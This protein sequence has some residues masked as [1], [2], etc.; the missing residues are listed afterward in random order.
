MTSLNSSSQGLLFQIMSVKILQVINQGDY[1]KQ[2]EFRVNTCYSYLFQISKTS[3][4]IPVLIFDCT[5]RAKNFVRKLQALVH[6]RK[7]NLLLF[8]HHLVAWSEYSSKVTRGRKYG[9]QQIP[10]GRL[11]NSVPCDRL[12]ELGWDSLGNSTFLRKA[13]F[14]F[15]QTGKLGGYLK[16]KATLCENNQTLVLDSKKKNPE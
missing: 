2:G 10:N 8:G 13:L 14:W 11:V 16:A 7:R 6:V 12:Y 9:G 15:L 3:Y 5:L 1:G 4:K